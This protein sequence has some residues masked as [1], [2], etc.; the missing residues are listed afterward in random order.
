MTCVDRRIWV[1]TWTMGI[2]TQTC[3][4][5]CG[6]RRWTYAGEAPQGR[7]K[8]GRLGENPGGR[9]WRGMCDWAFASSLAQRNARLA[10]L[11][12][13]ASLHLK[14][15]GVIGG[16]ERTLVDAVYLA[17]PVELLLNEVGIVG[18]HGKKCRRVA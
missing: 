1:D 16:A 3:G 15:V 9:A 18:G 17:R 5:F 10:E 11:L 6:T 4:V 13:N 14:V 2:K 12:E 8:P 7:K